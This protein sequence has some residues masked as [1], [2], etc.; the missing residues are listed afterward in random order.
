[1]VVC[2]TDLPGN[3]RIQTGVQYFQLS[4]KKQPVKTS[5]TRIQDLLRR[6]STNDR[7]RQLCAVRTFVLDTILIRHDRLRFGRSLPKKIQKGTRP[8]CQNVLRTYSLQLLF[9]NKPTCPLIFRRH[10][11]NTL[12]L[13]V[14]DQKRHEPALPVFET[15]LLKQRRQPVPER[16]GCLLLL[17]DLRLRHTEE[18]RLKRGIRQNHDLCFRDPLSES[19]IQMV[20]LLPAAALRLPFSAD[21]YIWRL[22]C[23]QLP[24]NKVRQ[25]LTR[26][27]QRHFK[28]WRDLGS[29][30]QSLINVES[31]VHFLPENKLSQ[32]MCLPGIRYLSATFSEDVSSEINERPADPEAGSSNRAPVPR[33]PF[34]ECTRNLLPAAIPAPD[35]PAFSL[36]PIRKDNISCY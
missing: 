11:V 33:Q 6:R 2:F 1:M 9:Q 24:A 21:N 23:V 14:L 8:Q 7:K 16:I 10:P 15:F 22:L 28:L 3:R 34:P 26:L 12:K 18:I 27:L 5:V 17:P 29:R 36:S 31:M 25:R 4:L 30:R 19:R 13:G 32:T 35:L 20:P